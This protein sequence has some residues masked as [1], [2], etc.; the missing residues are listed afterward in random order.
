MNMY[1]AF[2]MAYIASNLLACGGDENNNDNE[3]PNIENDVSIQQG[4]YGQV[5]SVPDFVPN[6]G[7][8]VVSDF[9]V[10]IYLAM[11]NLNSTPPDTPF[12]STNTNHK[13]F[14]ELPLQTGTYCL[15][16][17]PDDCTQLVINEDDLERADYAFSLIGAWSIEQLDCQEP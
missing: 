13:G 15:C 10:D 16:A 12:L 5:T 8:S 14:Y 11:P 17:G 7:P 3:V 9:S 6:N 4:V 1:K 2:I